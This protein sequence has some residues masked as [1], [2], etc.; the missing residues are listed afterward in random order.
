MCVSRLILTRAYAHPV[1]FSGLAS[2][3][4]KLTC[5]R[6]ILQQR[7]EMF[8]SG[9]PFRLSDGDPVLRCM[10]SLHFLAQSRS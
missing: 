4:L 1:R 2:W 10:S 5:R 6:G 3:M 9:S 7:S 8:A